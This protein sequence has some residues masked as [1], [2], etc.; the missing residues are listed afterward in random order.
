MKQNSLFGEVLST[1]TKYLKIAV[2]IVVVG[3]CLSGVRVVQ[4]GNV[5]LILRFGKLVGNTAQEQIHEPGLLLAFPYIIDEV[6]T[7]PTG[8]VM[9]Q[10]VST[11]YTEDDAYTTDGNYVLTG[12]QNVAILSASVKYIISDPVAYAL[13]VGDISSV[14]NA[15]VS[16]AMLNQA[17][18]SDVDDLLTGG[19]DQFATN[20]LAQAKEKVEKANIGITL[21]TVE[22]TKVAMPRE[23]REIYNQVT[24]T[25]VSAA[26]MLEQAQNVYNNTVSDAQ[27]QAKSLIANANSENAAQIAAANANHSEFWGLLEEYE[28]NPQ[29]VRTRL[30][31]QKVSEMVDKIGT[32][33]IVENGETNIFINP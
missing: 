12:D 5:A 8:S 11:Y 25:T 4:S 10:T 23:V 16:T 27:V 26:T 15:C 9:E 13:Q 30:Y 24:S 6:I 19:K 22:L 2:V 3:I 32:V 14:I 31:T 28:Q 21:T 29:V 1:V 20:V 17:A 18:N 7:V 33:K